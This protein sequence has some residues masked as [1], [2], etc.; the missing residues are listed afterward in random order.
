MEEKVPELEENDLNAL[1]QPIGEDN[2]VFSNFRQ[3]DAFGLEDQP[4]KP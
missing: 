2:S 3:K 4:K 1:P